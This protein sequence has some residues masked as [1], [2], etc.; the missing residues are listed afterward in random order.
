[1]LNN[2]KSF[3]M[4]LKLDEG[5]LHRCKI[6]LDGNQEIRYGAAQQLEKQLWCNN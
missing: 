4:A 1:M 6:F 3:Y 5:C 2:G